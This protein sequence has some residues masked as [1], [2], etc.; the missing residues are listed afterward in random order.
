MVPLSTCSIVPPTLE[1]C[2]TPADSEHGL[3]FG[4]VGR[5]T[6]RDD[7]CIVSASD[8]PTVIKF[9]LLGHLMWMH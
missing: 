2:T 7:L 5:G 9:T 6:Y 4:K 1:V 8:W 3:Q